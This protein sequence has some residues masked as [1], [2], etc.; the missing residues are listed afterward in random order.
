MGW[1]T[2]SHLFLSGDTMKRIL[3]LFSFVLAFW[4]ISPVHACSGQITFED[5]MRATDVFVKGRII[6]VDD[7][8]GNAILEVETYYV[9]SGAEFVTIFNNS[10]GV[11][12]HGVYDQCGW[13]LYSVAFGLPIGESAYFILHDYGISGVY[14]NFYSYHFPDESSTINL[15][16]PRPEDRYSLEYRDVNE[17]E[18]LALVAEYK[19]VNSISPEPNSI[20]IAS[21]LRIRTES[22]REY[23]LP[24]DGS[25]PI[26]LNATIYM[27]IVNNYM[28]HD[29]LRDGNLDDYFFIEDLCI[30][31]F[32]FSPNYVHLKTRFD[33]EGNEQFFL[34]SPTSETLAEWQDGAIVL[35]TETSWEAV[36]RFSLEASPVAH[37]DYAA[38]SPDGRFL[39]FSDARGL[40]LWDIAGEAR[41]LLPTG[42][43]AIPLAKRFSPLGNY[44][45]VQEGDSISYLRLATMESLPDGLFSP[46]E[47]RL[48]LY[49]T[50]AE[51]PTSLENCLVSTMECQPIEPLYES[52]TMQILSH[53]VWFSNRQFLANFCDESIES[54]EVEIAPQRYLSIVPHGHRLFAYQS[55]TELLAI[56]EG[57]NLLK[58]RKREFDS[59]RD[60]LEIELSL[61][62]PIAAMEWM[63]SFFYYM[64]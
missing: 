6:S 30:S 20:P 50:Q 3:V 22:G 37:P 12:N 26:E 36:N 56:L 35:Y 61:D 45:A 1:Q 48:L 33:G 27:S 8:G 39:A 44:L 31:C 62:S 42:H 43:V 19:D 16:F 11:I 41:L 25:S 53:P 60:I 10:I 59:M 40:W 32:V 46:D 38:W 18:F 9:G 15:S 34:Y 5:T 7:T 47:S 4:Q 14:R 63:P 28:P 21:A 23:L 24:P 13:G 55:G 64:D 49:D 57:D 2:L 58:I 51:D 54:C 29:G 52:R 17:T